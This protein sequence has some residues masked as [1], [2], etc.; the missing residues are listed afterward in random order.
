MTGRL[1]RRTASRLA[2]L[3]LAAL[4]AGGW[5]PRVR[6][7]PRPLPGAA[8]LAE[9]LE[10][11]S[12]AISELQLETAE[13]LLREL[14]ISHGRDPVV[15]FELARLRFY[16]GQY[17]AAVE[18]ADQAMRAPQGV[19]HKAWETMRRLMDSTLRVTR[20]FERVV[21]PDGR[22]AVWYP[23]GKDEILAH[24]ALDVLARADRELQ[25]A[26]GVTLP[27]PIRVEIYASPETLSQVSALTVEQIQT[28]GTVALSKWNRLMITSPKALVRGYPWADTITHELVH[29]VISRMTGDRA[30]VWLQE[31]TAK[32]FERAWRE[33]DTDLLLDPAARGLLQNAV[34][35]GKL[36]RFEQMHPS[37]AMLPSEDDAALAF[38]QV[39]TFMQ[40]YV[41]RFGTSAL[42]QALAD[43]GRGTDARDA[44]GNAAALPF[45]QIE[46]HWRGSLPVKGEAPAP[47]RLK[48]RFRNG[49]GPSDE[50]AEVAVAEARR[51]MRIGDLLWDRGR[52]SAAAR[53]Y[54]RAHRADGLDPIV[55]ARF[56]RAALEVGD[57]QGVVEALEPQVARYPSHAPTHALLGAARLQLGEREIAR[58]SLR[59]AIWI[60]PFDPDPHCNLARASDD[61]GELERERKACDELR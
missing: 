35:K 46:S 55:A 36:L 27:G 21:S 14:T 51:L 17:E 30:P 9:T 57:A 37:I 4:G 53:E 34:A 39:A 33:R 28:T 13:R 31:G 3:L 44:L 5:V 16:Q 18:L 43:I 49:E 8:A 47:R 7:A 56:G 11:A 25:R 15:V 22:Y 2:L 52:A 32:L 50:S 1:T 54:A 40:L 19:P 20:G 26:F 60:N 12:D 59:E 29:L 41:Q 48:P 42:R 10:R 58:H 38:A 6:A 24:Y 23:P 61:S 45:A